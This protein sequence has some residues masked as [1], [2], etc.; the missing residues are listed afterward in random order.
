MVLKAEAIA[1]IKMAF[2][3]VSQLVNDQ[4]VES[5]FSLFTTGPFENRRGHLEPNE[6]EVKYIIIKSYC[7]V[8]IFCLY[9]GD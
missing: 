1:V 9:F 7:L 3:L 2:D 4:K 6:Q 8:I 5:K